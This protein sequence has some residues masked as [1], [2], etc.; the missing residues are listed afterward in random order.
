MTLSIRWAFFGFLDIATKQPSLRL[1]AD[2][3]IFFQSTNR[4]ESFE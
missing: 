4:C 3:T 1:E 2:M